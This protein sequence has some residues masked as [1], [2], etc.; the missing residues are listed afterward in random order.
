MPKVPTMS[1]CLRW[2]GILDFLLPT[3]VGL[4]SQPVSNSSRYRS[5][6]FGEASARMWSNIWNMRF[7][8]TGAEIGSFWNRG[9]AANI[10]EHSSPSSCTTSPSCEPSILGSTVPYFGSPFRAHVSDYPISS[11]S[12]WSFY[13]IYCVRRWALRLGGATSL[14][15]IE[16]HGPRQGGRAWFG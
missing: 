13:I 9:Y 7:A 8:P 6:G 3:F 5:V 15:Y 11:A 4:I 14:D 2:S 16:V 12:V 1:L 10:S